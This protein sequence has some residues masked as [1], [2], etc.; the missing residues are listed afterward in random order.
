MLNNHFVIELSEGGK[1]EAGLCWKAA[2][3]GVY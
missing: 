2:E 3:V 1:K